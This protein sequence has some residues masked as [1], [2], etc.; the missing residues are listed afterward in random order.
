MINIQKIFNNKRTVKILDL[1]KALNLATRYYELGEPIVSDEEWDNAYFVLKERENNGEA[2]YA[3]SPTQS[4]SYDIKTKL[5]KVQHNHLMLSLDKSKNINDIYNF[6]KKDKKQPCIIMSKL[7]G[8]TC[9]LHY[10]NG[11]LIKAETRGNG[12]IGEDITHNLKVNYSVPQ[13]IEY[14]D[15]LIVDGEILCTNEDFSAFEE[16][17]KN[18]RNFAAGSIRLLDSH[19]CES[20]KLTFVVW[21]VIKGFEDVDLLSNKLERVNKLGFTIVPCF[22]IENK[23]NIQNEVETLKNQSIYPIDG[24]VVKFDSK[25]FS[26]SLG[27]TDHH[28]KN[29]IA[30]KFYDESYLT[31]ITGIEWTM[32]RSA[33]LT[34]VIKFEPVKIEGA[35]V[36]RASVHNLN[37][38]KGLGIKAIGQEVLVYRANMIIPQIAATRPIEIFSPEDEITIPKVCP[39]CGAKTIIKNDGKTDFLYCSNGFC[40]GKLINRLDHFCGIKGLDIKGLSKATLQK[41]IDWNWVSSIIDIYNLFS[42]KNE[43]KKQSGFGEKSVNNILQAIEDS[44]KCQ[45]E[46]FLAAIGIPLIGLNVSKEICKHVNSYKEFKEL[47]DNKFNFCEWDGFGP[48]KKE[49]LLNFDYKEADILIANYIEIIEKPKEDEKTN[50]TLKGLKICITGTLNNYKN[51]NELQKVI[52]AAG[53]KFIKSINK[54]TNYLINNNKESQTAKNKAAKQLGVKILTEE[55]F[56]KKFLTN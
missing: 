33:V 22:I 34:P 10:Q 13:Q 27:H 1:I 29:A 55:E 56:I 45:L 31:K 24:V 19:E 38:L 46:N 32:G 51:R 36:E 28:F 14:K 30:Y 23:N 6:I 40:S 50:H 4:I 5:E 53:G 7:D 47:I 21:E 54:S 18:P 15:E 12:Y 43:W 39:V 35:Y 48:E 2:I 41:L 3:C 52:E 26:A 17:F 49:S 8:L 11:K 42:I 9:S 37:I 44:K 20:R 16:D 25:T